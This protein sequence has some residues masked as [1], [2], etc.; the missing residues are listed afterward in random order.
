MT[1]EATSSCRGTSDLMRSDMVHIFIQ[2]SS[3]RFTKRHLDRVKSIRP[4]QARSSCKRVQYV[5]R[6]YSIWS[7]E[8]RLY[9]KALVVDPLSS[10][11]CNRCL[12]CGC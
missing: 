1:I 8:M 5:A 4:S 6:E 9:V 2:V 3:T 10:F 12:V 7:N 11:T